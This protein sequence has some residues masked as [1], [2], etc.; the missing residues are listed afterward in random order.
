MNRDTSRHYGT[1]K[2]EER[3]ERGFSILELLI[4]VSLVSV[5]FMTVLSSYTTAITLQQ[6][7]DERSKAM[8]IAQQKLEETA[9]IPYNELNAGYELDVYDDEFA[10][11]LYVMRIVSNLSD[12]EISDS[13]T[14]FPDPDPDAAYKLVTVSV[15]WGGGET[16]T[17]YEHL[18]INMIRVLREN[19]FD[20][21]EKVS[22]QAP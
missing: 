2:S 3:L 1:G 9:S 8:F 4:A 12:E 13:W 11:N 5:A 22:T 19:T 17:G 10:E 20:F 7:M 14:R 18:E 6:D 15:N 21:S 16:G